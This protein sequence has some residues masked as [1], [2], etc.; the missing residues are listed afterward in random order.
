MPGRTIV[1]KD[2]NS[3]KGLEA[4]HKVVEDKLTNEQLKKVADLLKTLKFMGYDSYKEEDVKAVLKMAHFNKEEAVDIVLN[5]KYIPWQSRNKKEAK[6]SSKKND[7]K[8]KSSTNKSKLE[9]VS[10]NKKP[11]KNNKYHRREGE[12]ELTVYTSL[13]K[14][15]E[16]KPVKE[17]KP[18]AEVK[19]DVQPAIEVDDNKEVVDT[20]QTI[21]PEEVKVET[22]PAEPIVEVIAENI[23][24]QEEAEP[25][26]E[27]EHIVEEAPVKCPETTEDAV[28]AVEPEVP[29]EK[30][31]EEE[32]VKEDSEQIDF[33]IDE[34]EQKE[35]EQKKEEKVE[36]VTAATAP[37]TVQQV[38][39]QP[40]VPTASPVAPAIPQMLPPFM[41]DP[42]FMNY[43][44]YQYS[45]MT[46]AQMQQG[47]PTMP[48]MPVPAMQPGMP[49]MNF[50]QPMPGMPQG[51]PFPQQPI[52]YPQQ[53]DKNA[54]FQPA[55]FF[56][57]YQFTRI[58]NFGEK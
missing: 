6:E 54:A 36:A 22:V 10:G 19:T 12:Y 41:Y 35:E 56:M 38:P 57:P 33:E 30:V 49:G 53:N 37:V 39:A 15:P 48:Q 28:T 32:V 25:E 44:F 51:I 13:A 45:M 29:A 26:P 16:P 14:K 43:C 52:P 11:N 50:P 4:S 55:P 24:V 21:E 31:Q 3:A 58:P 23:E 34:E 7:K 5:D 42:N 9:V 40:T 47:L 8:N 17:E 1:I 18:A 20:A 46:H 2:I 27:K